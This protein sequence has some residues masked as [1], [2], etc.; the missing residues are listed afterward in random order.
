MGRRR[1]RRTCVSN[2]RT[3]GGIVERPS[4]GRRQHRTAVALLGATAPDRPS[5]GLNHRIALGHVSM[6]MTHCLLERSPP[7]ELASSSRRIFSPTA[8]RWERKTRSCGPPRIRPTPPARGP[9]ER[10]KRLFCSSFRRRPLVLPVS[11]R[12]IGIS[13]TESFDARNDRGRRHEPPSCK[14]HF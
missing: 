12:R 3:T 4:A 5:S 1:R 10:R 9:C 8:V 11:L 14:L 6:A 7:L 2:P 13:D